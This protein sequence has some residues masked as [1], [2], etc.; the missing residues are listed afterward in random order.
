MKTFAKSFAGASLAMVIILL[1]VYF[2]TDFSSSL[3]SNN[4]TSDTQSYD[5][6]PATPIQNVS[7]GVPQ[8]VDFT[9]AA[10]KTVN[11]V[12][13]IKTEM[14]VKTSNYDNFFGA[15]R[16]YFGNPHRNNTYVAF[17][18]GVIISPDGYI[19]T[20][21]HVVEGADRIM[22]TFNDKREL[23]GELIGNDP[24][25]DLALIKV[26]GDELTY[27]TYG[28]S[29]QI[30]VGE[31]VLAVG[32]PFN[33]TST[34]TA[35]IVSAKA[36][37]INILGAQSSIES[38]IQTD[39]VVNRGNSGGALVNTSGDLVGINAAIASHT[40]VYE[41]YSFAIPVNIVGKVV[42]DLMRYGEIQRAYIGV[43]ISDI[44]AEFAEELG[45]NKI[46]G[47]YI[48]SV[49]E[50]GGADDAGLRKGDVILAIDDTEINSVSELMGT[51]AQH[52]PG[53]VVRVRI[54]RDNDYE[55]YN[56]T[57]K[58][59]NQT[60]ALVKST[61]AFYNDLLGASMQKASS[62]DLN[63]LG[64]NGGLKIVDIEDGILRRGGISQ[65]FIITDVNGIRVN[66]ENSLLEAIQSSRTNSVSLR[67]IYP[68]GTRV[69][70]E[71]ML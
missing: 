68:N 24:T 9:T 36:R 71:F 59:Q 37:N 22:V 27:L 10:E 60:T 34:V 62:N 48:A 25:T 1:A 3:N 35:G 69:S 61:D 41:G 58:N 57:L 11:A 46:E 39:A 52:N 17:G 33:L 32:N 38:F 45:L 40:G 19:V 6:Y 15:F 13:H 49:V 70:Y 26:D 42:E 20:N 28:N 55:T 66:S 18:S 29:D 64:L 53:D 56:V 7:Y 16:D 12:V 4:T 2:T 31:W 21:N 14:R 5:E 54:N 23:E 47:I 65:G 43:Q 67:G 50:D 63:K 44:N 8:N 51:V 30:K